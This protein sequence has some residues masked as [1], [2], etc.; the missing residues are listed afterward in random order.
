MGNFD[1]IKKRFNK[2]QLIVLNKS[3]EILHSDANLFKDWK[4][5]IS[6]FDAHPFFEIISTLDP[7][8]IENKKEFSFPCVHLESE[9]TKEKICDI[10]FVFEAKEIHIL[11]FDYTTTYQQLNIISQEK[12]DSIIKSQ[13]L[14]FSNKLLLEKE[15]FKNRFIA[16]INHELITPLTSIKGFLELFEKTELSYEQEELIRIIKSESS[17]LQS[18]FR[19]MLDVSRI[20]SGEFSL[21]SETFDFI[22]LVKEIEESHRVITESKLLKLEVE[23]DKKINP[24][25]HTDKTRLYQILS[26]LIG[27]AIKYTDTGL[28]KLEINKIS[29]KSKKQELEI[30][31]TDTG[32]G[33]SESDQERIFEPFSQLNDLTQ[34]S[35][36]GL[37]VTRNLVHLMQGSISLKSKAGEG[38]EF[39]ISLKLQ[40]AKQSSKEAAEKEYKLP[41]GKKYRIL[42][43]ENRLNTQYLIM[44]QLLSQNCFFVDA[45]SNAEDALTSI[46][47]RNYDLVIADIKLPGI[48][49]LDLAKKIRNNYADT[50]IKNVA[51]LG[52]SGVQ[53]P[54]ILNKAIAHGMD[55]FLPKP[56][57]ENEL[58]QK[59]SRLLV[60]RE[61]A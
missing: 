1:E 47:N 16:N 29:G 56:F 45:V 59:I 23:V 14:E 34:G 7:S 17:Y 54:N 11:I 46:E 28:I 57:T 20:E 52:L 9:T 19:D 21:K 37:H 39:T 38:S 5:K 32:I 22:E 51:I 30:K 10:T 42:V 48:S 40:T 8:L 55:Y 6:I 61:N 27:N 33:I 50:A 12:N 25:V 60:L 2:S 53:V 24:I 26:S 13:E 43:V 58:L 49:G 4:P 44:K 35:G 15:K 36:L 31:V 18:I 41:E 3:G